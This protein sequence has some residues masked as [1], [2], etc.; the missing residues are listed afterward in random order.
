MGKLLAAVFIAACVAMSF[1]PDRWVAFIADGAP[2]FLTPSNARAIFFVAAIIVALL[3]LMS[4]L[5]A[6]SGAKITADQIEYGL[7][8]TGPVLFSDKLG[9]RKRNIQLGVGLKNVTPHLLRYDVDHMFVSVN[10]VA[11]DEPI[12]DNTGLVLRPGESDVFRYATFKEL[13][14][15]PESTV[16][17]STNISYGPP[18]GGFIRHLK[19]EYAC[20]LR[21]TATTQ[22]LTFTISGEDW[23]QPI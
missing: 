9:K 8:V 16:I 15:P 10:G 14:L 21:V 7:A 12:Y 3:L 13:Q 23:D 4:L 2:A 19:R 17:V 18:M 5:R 22:N 1:G 6:S 20:V 11:M